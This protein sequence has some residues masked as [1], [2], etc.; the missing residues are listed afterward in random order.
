M[1]N[2]NNPELHRD[3]ELVTLDSNKNLIIM[4]PNKHAEANVFIVRV[5][6]RKPRKDLQKCLLFIIIYYLSYEIVI[7]RTGRNRIEASNF[8]VKWPIYIFAAICPSQDNIRS[9]SL[10]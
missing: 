3:L 1:A 4:I 2:L 7:L 5:K 10:L 8:N 9:F 6:E